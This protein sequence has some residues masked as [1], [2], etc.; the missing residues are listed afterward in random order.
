[1]YLTFDPLIKTN[2][3]ITSFKNITL[4]KVNINPYGF[5]KMDMDKEL[6]E[7]RIY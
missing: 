7:Y 6:V 2:N 1:M 5:D 3:I 4:R